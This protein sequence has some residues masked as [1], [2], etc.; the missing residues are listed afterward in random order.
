MKVML[1]IADKKKGNETVAR[2][3]H[4]AS[5]VCIYDSQSKSMDR[6]PVK[7]VFSNPGE[8][9]K[10]LQ[11]I[12]VSTVISGYLPPMALRLFA[13]SGLEVFRARGTNV[14]ENINFFIQNQ[15]ESFTT[16]KARETW[17]CN[18]SCGSCSSTTCN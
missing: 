13:R 6:M 14:T 8:L 11:Q 12:G 17:G 3:F 5:Y 7:A 15:L 4:N 2:G 9:G 10:E 16:Q 1:P 18:S